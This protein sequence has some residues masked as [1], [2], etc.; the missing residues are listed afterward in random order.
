MTRYAWIITDANTGAALKY[1][2]ADFNGLE[3]GP[4]LTSMMD[5]AYAY[6]I[7]NSSTLPDVVNIQI[8]DETHSIEIFADKVTKK[9]GRY[10]SVPAGTPDPNKPIPAFDWSW[11]L[12]LGLG[13]AII[14]VLYWAYRR[15]LQ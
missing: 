2:A 6:I 14:V 10:G 4:G 8:V 11:L 12:Y 15:G 3:F 7:A 5:A 1:D 13:I 9:N